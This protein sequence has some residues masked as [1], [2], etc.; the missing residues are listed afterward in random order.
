MVS[1]C[2]YSRFMKTPDAKL[3]YA[4]LGLEPNATAEQLRDAYRELVKQWH[5][6]KVAHN[7]KLYAIAEEELK[8]INVAYDFLQSHL[9]TTEAPSPSRETPA[10]AENKTQT[11][12]RKPDEDTAR[13]RQE[14]E[15]QEHEA[16]RREREAERLRVQQKAEAIYQQEQLAKAQEAAKHKEQEAKR[17]RARASDVK[18]RNDHS[19]SSHIENVEVTY[20][21]QPCKHPG[22]PRKRITVSDFC[23]WHYLE[24]SER[25]KPERDAANGS[26]AT[27]V[28]YTDRPCKCHGCTRRRTTTSVFCKWHHL[29]S[30]ER[31]RRRHTT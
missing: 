31:S 5:P 29:E 19:A 13:Q 9:A 25:D 11:G 20:T 17:A 28:V 16:K 24:V 12:D 7:P 21:T 6:D 23:K 30:I 10:Q 27:E 4:T 1:F 2:G 26:E 14:R 15:R 18:P 3:C 22:C 8:V